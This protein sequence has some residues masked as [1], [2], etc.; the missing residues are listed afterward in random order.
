MLFRI[1]NFVFNNR[2]DFN[3]YIF[4]LTLTNKL[5]TPLAEYM[6]FNLFVFVSLV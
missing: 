3:F 1:L 2:V 6:Y 4:N 5:D